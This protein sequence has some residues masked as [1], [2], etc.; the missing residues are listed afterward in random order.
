MMFPSCFGQEGQAL[1]SHQRAAFC[2]KQGSGFCTSCRHPQGWD[3]SEQLC[4][5]FL[6]RGSEE[7][8]A[9]TFRAIQDVGRWWP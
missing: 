9:E 3:D 5:M 1:R 7:A 4:L 6:P 2:V 8:I